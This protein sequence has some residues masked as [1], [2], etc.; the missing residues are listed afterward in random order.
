[1]KGTSITSSVLELVRKFPGSTYQE[2]AKQS[3]GISPDSIHKRLPELRRRGLVYSTDMK[4]CSVSRREA[5][6]WAPVEKETV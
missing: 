1:M 5:Q 6:G 2:L 3:W 4:I